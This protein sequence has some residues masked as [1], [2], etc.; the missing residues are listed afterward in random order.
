MARIFIIEDDANLANMICDFMEGENHVIHTCGN[1]REGL[2]IL[3]RSSYDIIL[4]DCNLP[5]LSGIDLCSSFR[6]E[7]GTT[8]VIMITARGELA[9]KELGYKAGV[10]D[11]LTKPFAIKELSLKIAAVLKRCGVRSEETLRIRDIEFSPGSASIKRN[12][13]EI[14]LYRSDAALL[15]FLIRHP[16]QVFSPEALLEHVY[17]THASYTPEAV[18]SSIKRIRQ[19]VDSDPDRSIIRTIHRV[20]Y[21]L[22]P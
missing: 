12:G 17:S 16:N 14:F 3:R 4:L 1:G 10:D 22:E 7:G 18:R 20:G 15:E 13:K 2:D 21:R 9:D 8:P 11:Y 6:D 19:S 5:E